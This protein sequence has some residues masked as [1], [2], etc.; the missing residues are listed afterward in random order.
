MLL[1]QNTEEHDL[2]RLGRGSEGA[3]GWPGGNGGGGG[4]VGRETFGQNRILPCTSHFSSGPK[5]RRLKGVG[6]TFPYLGSLSFSTT[7]HVPACRER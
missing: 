3:T 6:C 5:T 2:Q 7:S 1:K 4:G